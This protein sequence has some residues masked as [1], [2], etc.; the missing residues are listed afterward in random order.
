[1]FLRLKES[2]VEDEDRPTHPA[3]PIGVP[4]AAMTP[5]HLNTKIL[6]QSSSPLKDKGVPANKKVGEFDVSTE[7]EGYGLQ[8]VRVTDD[9][10]R[11]LV[12]EL[13]L[14]G[15]EAGDLVKG[16]SG[17]D[18]D[19]GAKPLFKSTETVPPPVKEDIDKP[20]EFESKPNAGQ[21]GNSVQVVSEKEG[22][23]EL[24]KET[25]EDAK[26]A[27]VAESTA[28]SAFGATVTPGKDE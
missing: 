23:P 6:A 19:D 5:E 1:M 17:Q 7:L 22:K 14:H 4:G 2:W 18:V 13:G 25:A 11:D 9:E 12:A 10:L 28:A 3:A 21:T 20:E 15:D 27:E 16:L 24:F 26:P 8:G